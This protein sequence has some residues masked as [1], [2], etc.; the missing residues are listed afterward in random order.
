MLFF[1]FTGRGKKMKDDKAL[2][3]ENLLRQKYEEL[4]KAPTK[5]DFDEVTRSRIKAALGPWPRALEAA[6][7]KKAKTK[8]EDKGEKEK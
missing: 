4:G 6:G 3:A 1:I 7:I 8:V 5:K 2:W